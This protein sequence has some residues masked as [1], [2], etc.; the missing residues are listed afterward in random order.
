MPDGEVMVAGNIWWCW[1]NR[2]DFFIERERE[3]KNQ[4]NELEEERKSLTRER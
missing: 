4:K 1:F 3:S 2:G